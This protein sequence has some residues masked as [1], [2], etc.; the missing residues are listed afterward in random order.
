M[1]DWLSITDAAARLTALGDSIDRSTLSRY[2]KQHAEALPVRREGR[3]GLV[4]FEALVVHRRENIRVEQKPAP[5]LT[6]PASAGANAVADATAKTQSVG[7]ARKALADAELR[8]MDLAERR[9]EL[10]P[11]REVDESGRGSVVLMQSA[12]DRAI[13]PMAS[14]CA[15]KYGWNERQVRLVLKS[16]ARIGLDM[17]H[18]VML[19]HLDAM[20]SEAELVQD[21]LVEDG[22]LAV[23]S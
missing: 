11:T 13:E 12:F 20:A 16:Y 5:L 19:Q 15:I 18:R 23:T 7:A 1:A 4:E 2:L 14:E 22:A 3:S 9:R 8:E 10:T 21:D 6:A 17:F